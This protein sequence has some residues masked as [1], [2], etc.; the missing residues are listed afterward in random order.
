MIKPF[1]NEDIHKSTASKVFDVPLK[2]SLENNVVMQKRWILEYMEFQL[3]D[4]LIKRIYPLWK[5]CF[6]WSYYKTYP[7]LKSYIS[8]QIDFARENGYVQTVWV[9]VA[10]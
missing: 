5:C 2:K 9:A 7:R 6:N 4:F 10:I 3:L 1:F 8:E